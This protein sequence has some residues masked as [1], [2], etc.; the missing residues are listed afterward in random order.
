MIAI[1]GSWEGHCSGTAMETAIVGVSFRQALIRLLTVPVRW[2]WYLG[3][4]C[5]VLRIG[6]VARAWRRIGSVISHPSCG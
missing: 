1:M 3:V 5:G 4:W 2:C 6:V